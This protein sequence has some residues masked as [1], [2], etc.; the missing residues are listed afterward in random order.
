MNPLTLVFVLAIA[1]LAPVQQHQVEHAHSPYAGE[2]DSEIPALTAEQLRQLENGEGMG[3]ARAAELNHY[4]GPKHALELAE[5]LSLSA[6]QRVQIVEIRDRMKAE[7]IRLGSEILEAECTL[8]RRFEHQHIDE[9]ALRSAIR[10]IA[11]LNGELRYVHLAAHLET[12]RVLTPEQ[13]QAYDQ[14]RG[15]GHGEPSPP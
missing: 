2:E 14:L 15:Y 6:E 3:L 13:V 4:P 7:A 10:E 8:N 1:G 9:A 12:T 11:R 5:E